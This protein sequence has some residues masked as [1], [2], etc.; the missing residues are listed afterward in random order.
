M[1]FISNCQLIK[2][3]DFFYLQ[4]LLIVML[5]YLYELVDIFC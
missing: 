5:C 1:G 4:I 2:F 3:D